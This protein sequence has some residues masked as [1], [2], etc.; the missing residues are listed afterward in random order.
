MWHLPDG[1]T[2]RVVAI[3]NADGGMTY[4][5]ENVTEQITLESRLDGAACSC[6]ARRSTI[7]PRRWRCSARTGGSASSIPS[8]PISG[9]SRRPALRAEPHIG[10]IIATCQAIYSD[11]AA[12][13]AIRTAVTDLDHD[14]QAVGRMAA[15][16]AA[17]STTRPS[18]FPKA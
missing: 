8:S 10:E 4:I 6:R 1:R 13:D 16:T 2:L 18:R 15:P 12:W 14:D 11:K 17:S 3:P 5:Y 7:W 9:G